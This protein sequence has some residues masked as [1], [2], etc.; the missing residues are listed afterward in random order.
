MQNEKLVK[1]IKEWTPLSRW[2]R[3]KP[4][5]EDQGETGLRDTVSTVR[6]DCSILLRSL[7]SMFL[8]TLLHVIDVFNENTWIKKT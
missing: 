6:Q 8:S 1:K 3:G 2:E 5:I 4:N 7:Y